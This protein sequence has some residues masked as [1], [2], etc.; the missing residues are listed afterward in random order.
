MTDQGRTKGDGDTNVEAKVK[1]LEVQNS[2][3]K[4]ELTELIRTYQ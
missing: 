1:E 2:E 3:L 4:Q